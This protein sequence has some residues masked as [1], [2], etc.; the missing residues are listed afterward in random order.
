MKKAL[1]FFVA[2]AV[3]FSTVVCGA[4]G[5]TQTVQAQGTTEMTEES[6]MKN[7]KTPAGQTIT[8]LEY[9]TLFNN[10]S[11]VEINEKGL[12]LKSN[13]VDMVL[14]KLKVRYKLPNVEA[15]LLSL[16]PSK[17]PQLKAMAICNLEHSATT[18]PKILNALN[19]ETNLFVIRVGISALQNEISSDENVA[20]FILG[21]TDN[22][23]LQIRLAVAEAICK[24][25]NV[26]V[27]GV[28]D[29]IRKFMKDPE[30]RVRHTVLERIGN[31]DDDSFVEDLAK[32]VKNDE[33]VSDHRPALKS[34]FKLWYNASGNS[35]QQAYN[36]TIDYLTKKPRTDKIPAR[37]AISHM[38]FAQDLTSDYYVKKYEEWK[39]KNDFYS[40]SKWIEI[41]TDIATDNNADDAVRVSAVEEVAAI[42]SKE[43]LESLKAKVEANPLSDSYYQGNMIKAIDKALN[44]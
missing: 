6:L 8:L 37:D 44:K 4:G 18:T 38:F 11:K 20:K 35:S 25:S 28:M 12:S 27:P 31:F 17:T 7:I 13:P 33:L 43:Y 1:K 9:K 34:L 21:Y 14:T 2:A 30:S 39:T 19:T 16:L 29:A 42:A 10:Y 40:E 26:S 5:L 23:N 36:V 3:T 32:I 15:Y 22:E 24:K 41:M